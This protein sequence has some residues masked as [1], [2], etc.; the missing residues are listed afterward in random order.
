MPRLHFILP[1][2]VL[3]ACGVGDRAG[4]RSI[5]H[6]GLGEGAVHP[7]NSWE[8]LAGGLAVGL[9]GIE[10]DVQLTADSVLVAYHAETLEELTACSGKINA[11]TWEQLKACSNSAEGDRPY[12]IIRAD[13][14]IGALAAKYPHA[15]F[16]L[17]CKLFAVGDWWPYLETYTSALAR[18]ESL[19]PGKVL[20]EC[21]VDDFL[22]LLQRKAPALPLFLYGSDAQAAM[23]RAAASHYAGIT[24]DNDR[25][26]AEEVQAAHDLGL[27]VT[28]F[29][30]A[31]GLEH[32]QAFAKHPD[33]VQTD[34]PASSLP[35]SKPQ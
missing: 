1:L 17:D 8:A 25:I 3:S 32:R 28:V 6:G 29:N 10:L 7:M 30:V 33:R 5:G 22:L 13:A 12:P 15:D 16:T 27:Q 23:D 20:V 9:D 24:I 26:G 19:H 21:Q 18:L 2:M 35:N 31:G 14:L 34:H 11:L 4:T